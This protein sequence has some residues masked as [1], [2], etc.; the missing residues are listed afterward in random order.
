M[1]SKID[2]S[3][4]IGNPAVLK[5]VN[6]V[7]ILNHL[8]VDGPTS[9]AELARATGLDAK[10]ITNICNSLFTKGLIEAQEAKA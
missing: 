8:R 3:T 5:Q 4:L 9:R 10:T 1:N 6:M 7:R 2:L